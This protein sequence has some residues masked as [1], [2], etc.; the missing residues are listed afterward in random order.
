M[1]PENRKGVVESASFS[2]W[3]AMYLQLSWEALC[4]PR[5]TVPAPH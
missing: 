3:T 5:Q 2:T 4:L 1:K